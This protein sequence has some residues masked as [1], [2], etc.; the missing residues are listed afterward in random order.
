[1]IDDEDWDLSML[2][3]NEIKRKVALRHFPY[4]PLE[5]IYGAK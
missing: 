4:N 2:Y 5:S 3:I 1:M